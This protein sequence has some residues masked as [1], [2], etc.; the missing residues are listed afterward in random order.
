V[1]PDQE[2][3]SNEADVEALDVPPIGPIDDR[4][5]PEPAGPP[6]R[7]EVEQHLEK[8]QF[9]QKVETDYRTIVESLDR[10]T[11]TA[12]EAND[13]GC[14]W[15]W[16]AY[17]E[18]TDVHWDQAFSALRKARDAASTADQQNPSDESADALKRIEANLQAVT[19]AWQASTVSA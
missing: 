17:L 15:A 6:K 14:A 18:Q 16:R 5:E 1:A 8:L 10:E 3:V 7:P 12:D 19:D 4:P 9:V 11:L 13:L 2:N